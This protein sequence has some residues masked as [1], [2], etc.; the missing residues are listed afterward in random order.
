V[1]FLKC[2][3]FGALIALAPACKNASSAAGTVAPSGLEVIDLEVASS[4]KVH[5]FK[6]EVASTAEQQTRGLMFRESLPPFGGMIFPFP[7]PR[8]AGFWMKDT[9]IPLDMIFIRKD[10]T[11]A[12]IAAETIPYSLETVDSGEPVSA[13]LEIAGGRA[14]QLGIQENDKVSW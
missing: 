4:G 2:V 11:I 3:V 12:R 8:P 13:V 5:K 14:A 1:K 10:G 9:V 7:Q 6:V